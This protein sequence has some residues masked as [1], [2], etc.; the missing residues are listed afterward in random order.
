MKKN[1]RFFIGGKEIEFNSDPKILFNYKVTDLTNPSVVRNSYTKSIE[2]EGTPRNNEVFENIWNLQ[3]VQFSGLNFNPIKKTDFVIY[4]NGEIYEKGYA[5]LDGITTKNNKCTYSITLFG[6]LGSFFFNL[7]FK[8]SEGD[9]KK[10]LADLDY[11]Q[12]ETF[13][14]GSGVYNNLNPNLDFRINKDS[15]YDAWQQIMG[16]PDAVYDENNV[17]RPQNYLWDDRW[18]VINFAPCYNGIPEDFDSS[19]AIINKRNMPVFEFTKEEGGITYTDYNGYAMGEQPNDELTE[20]DTFDLRSYLMRPVVKMKRVIDAVCN[21]LNNGGYEIVLDSSFFNTDNPYYSSS[22]MTLPML[23]ETV[24]GGET[25]DVTSATIVLDKVEYDILRRYNV[26]YL[27]PTISSV[28]NVNMDLSIE[29]DIEGDEE[30]YY[31]Y[32]KTVSTPSKKGDTT[33]I[34][35]MEQFSNISLQLV[36]YDD[37]DNCVASSAVFYI[38]DE[39]AAGKTFDD[40]SGWHIYK[41]KNIPVPSVNTVYGY[42]SRTDGGNYRL[43]DTDGNDL[44][45]GFSFK[46]NTPFKRL[47]LL[48]M[49]IT[50]Y[51]WTEKWKYQWYKDSWYNGFH[52]KIDKFNPFSVFSSQYEYYGED[53]TPQA[54]MERDRVF[55][56]EIPYSPLFSLVSTDYS[57]FFSNTLIKKEEILKTENTPA[58][59]LISFAK[60]FGLYFYSNPAEEA[61]NPELAPNGVIHILTRDTYYDGE[62][63]DLQPYIDRNKGIKIT[64]ATMDS[65]WFNFNVE[66]TESEANDEHLSKYGYDYGYQKINTGYN[67][68]AQNKSLLE[69]IAYKGGIEALQT[70]KYYQKPIQGYPAYAYNGFKY[71]LFN[72]GGEDELSSLEISPAVDLMYRESISPN[73]WENTDAF[74]K[75]QF[76]GKDNSSAEGNNVLLFF[77]NNT[78]YDDSVDYWIT[79]DIE[80]MVTL[81]D[82]NPCWIMTADEFNERNER[83][84]YRVNRLPIFERNIVNSGNGVI[85][86]SWDFGDPFITF[87]RDTYVGEKGGLYAK[88]WKDYISD[89]YSEDNRILSTYVVFPERPNSGWL[90]KFYFFDNTLWRMNSIKE[91]NLGGYE[92]TA[93]EFVK[94]IDVNNYR[95]EPITSVIT[96][97]F[98]FPELDEVDRIDN[99]RWYEIGY[100]AKDI[101]GVIDVGNADSWVFGDGAG[102]DFTVE[103]A[104][105]T[106]E[107]YP[108]LDIVTPKQDTGSGN[109]IIVFSIPRNTSGQE[110][111]FTF[112]IT[113]DADRVYI[114]H[115]TQKLF[116]QDAGGGL[117]W[118]DDL[119]I[120][121]GL[122]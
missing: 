6:G 113:D 28:D 10:S 45:M 30:N 33:R 81:N 69:K 13:G 35:V 88:C 50:N 31:M 122:F 110:R 42:F 53:I 39:K 79:D 93:V 117:E 34:G 119:E 63:I 68:N 112:N 80:E 15:M 97:D 55:A 51:K 37:L 102:A 19:K 75:P 49:P 17:D 11:S 98:Y 21:P 8:D 85:K 25:Y 12:R 65:K 111:T 38:Q 7:S 78:W 99:E 82:G 2:I 71:S 90:R 118:G 46:G 70:S 77:D 115:V 1:I 107:I 74:K 94:V 64:P 116:K 24:E 22:Y 72:D 109:A 105:G 66:Q 58:D 103:Y 114:C 18:E 32:R 54:A 26:D 92:P 61:K 100:L 86:H 59:Y 43:V 96:A 40:Y 101:K 48:T 73:G 62:I 87:V 16:N 76:H 20:Y 95:L 44:I 27:L 106:I 47:E 23:R 108:Y 3:R 89:L 14:D 121:G 91:W 83:I 104:D 29:L 84:A 52:N 60:M 5:K 9:D 56:T 120:E 41:D 4:V 36:A 57:S 67:F